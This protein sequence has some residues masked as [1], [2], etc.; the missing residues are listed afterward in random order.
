L[1]SIR[2]SQQAAGRG[3]ATQDFA[4]DWAHQRATCPQGKTSI[5]WTPAV[6]NRRNEVVKIKF[7]ARD[8]QPC[9][10]RAEGTRSRKRSP[11][12]TLIVRREAQFLALQA[13]RD[14][15]RTAA[16]A[17]EYARRRGVEGTISQGVRAGGLRRSRYVGQVKTHLDHLLTAA[18][19]NC[20]RLDDWL[21]G[22]P[23]AT[24]RQA[25]FVRLL[26][27]APSAASK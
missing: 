5:S 21:A 13:S 11:R 20:W 3:H 22:V 14:R 10:A 9:P 12:R 2:A 16:Y 23:R 24:T 26:T 1:T 17:A 19:L 8:C 18:A 6:D 27:P 15:A 25:P 4:L 7:S